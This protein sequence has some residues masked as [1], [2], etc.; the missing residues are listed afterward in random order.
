MVGE[1][2]RIKL[3]HAEVEKAIVAAAIA[4]AKTV[5]DMVEL[6][7]PT[8][9]KSKVVG[10]SNWAGTTEVVELELLK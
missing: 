10:Q 3:D 6:D 4:K 7:N 9:W 5:I 2:L 8:R 1:K